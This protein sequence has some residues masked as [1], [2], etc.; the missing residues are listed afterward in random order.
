MTYIVH[1]TNAANQTEWF[2]LT[3]GWT[4]NP[5]R[6]ARIHSL[7]CAKQL[8]AEFGAHVVTLP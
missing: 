6:M 1:R 5:L 2:S 7:S 3:E 4:T 8:A